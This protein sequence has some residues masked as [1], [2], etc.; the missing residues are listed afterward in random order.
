[1]AC[2]TAAGLIFFSRAS[3]LST[4]RVMNLESTSKKLRSADRLSLLPK[5]SVPK[6][7]I[8]RGH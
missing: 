1:M 7:T 6:E 2:S 3:S 8:G 4:A 5:P